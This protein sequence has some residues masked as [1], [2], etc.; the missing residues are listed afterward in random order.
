MYWRLPPRSGLFLRRSY[1]FSSIFDAGYI[2]FGIRDL[3]FR[4]SLLQTGHRGIFAILFFC[5]VL[6]AEIFRVR[7]RNLEEHCKKISELG[8]QYLRRYDLWKL[9]LFAG[10]SI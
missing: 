9:G 7:S 3:D 1:L 4:V 5:E 2:T 8:L 6:E 10:S